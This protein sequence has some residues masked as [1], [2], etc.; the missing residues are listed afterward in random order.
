[1]M[2]IGFGF[3]MTFLR[4][5]G[6]SG[7]GCTLYLTA[8]TLQLALLADGVTTANDGYITLNVIR[9]YLYPHLWC[10]LWIGVLEECVTKGS[11]E[12]PSQRGLRLHP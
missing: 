3:L 1:M 7:L 8:L 6:H 5:Y 2:V 11:C 9:F 12:G 10:L 4:R